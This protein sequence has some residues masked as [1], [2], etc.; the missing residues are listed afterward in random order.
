MEEVLSVKLHQI[1][2]GGGAGQGLLRYVGSSRF[3]GV[4]ALALATPCF[5]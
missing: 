2:E 3:V 5:G 1:V 4:E